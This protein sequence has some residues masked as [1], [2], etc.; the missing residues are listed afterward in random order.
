[1]RLYRQEARDE[2]IADIGTKREFGEENSG[3]GL[4]LLAGMGLRPWEM[5]KH[6][7]AVTNGC[8]TRSGLSTRYTQRILRHG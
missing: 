1:L 3:E 5:R 4:G 6:V 8:T 2:R 7:P